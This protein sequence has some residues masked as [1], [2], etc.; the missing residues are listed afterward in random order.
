VAEDAATED[1]V[2]EAPDAEVATAAAVEATEG[3]TADTEDV[4]KS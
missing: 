4:T 3:A 1:D 2:E